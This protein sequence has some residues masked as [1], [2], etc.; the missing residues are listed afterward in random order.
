MAST[1]REQ[2]KYRDSKAFVD[3]THLCENSPKFT[4]AL[5]DINIAAQLGAIPNRTPF[6]ATQT[7][8]EHIHADT[9]GC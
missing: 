3:S 1:K 7:L 5:A 6:T 9:R 2:R 4:A 8:F